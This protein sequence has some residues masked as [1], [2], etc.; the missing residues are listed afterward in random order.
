[1]R[2]PHQASLNL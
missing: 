2:F 1:M